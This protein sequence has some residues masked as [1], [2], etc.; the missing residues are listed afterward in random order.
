MVIISDQSGNTCCL[1]PFS[2]LLSFCISM[3]FLSATSVSCI[4]RAFFEVFHTSTAALTCM[5]AD[6]LCHSSSHISI[7]GSRPGSW[8]A[9][10]II[11][12]RITL[13]FHPFQLF[14]WYL[15]LF[16]IHDQSVF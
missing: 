13:F 5:S 11:H 8:F 2:F 4:V 3:S 16:F 12:I 6:I 15:C 7:S 14:C 1:Y 9:V 10:M